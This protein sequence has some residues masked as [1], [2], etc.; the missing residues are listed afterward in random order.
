MEVRHQNH[1]PVI[2]QRCT[3]K[4]RLFSFLS[5]ACQVHRRHSL[6]EHQSVLTLSVRRGAVAVADEG[7]AVGAAAWWVVRRPGCSAVSAA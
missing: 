1:H 4:N 3:P 5:F 2:E 6:A 7:A